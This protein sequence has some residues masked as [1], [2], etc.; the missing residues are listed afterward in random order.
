L[1]IA[2]LRE[3]AAGRATSGELDL[4]TERA[5]LA[6]E[7]RIRIE[8]QNDITRRE[9]GPIEA[10]EVGLTDV[11]VRVASKLDTVPGKL[12]IKSDKLTADDIAV[13]EL[14]LAEVRNEIADM[15]IDWFDDGVDLGSE[16]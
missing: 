6:Q 9:Y 7:Q 2:Q 16:E 3:Q 5:K 11:L 8:M 4:A 15:E 10:L 14:V 1:Y 13:V 12:K